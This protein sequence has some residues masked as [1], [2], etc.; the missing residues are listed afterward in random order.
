[1][2][3]FNRKS[4]K[5]ESKKVKKQSEKK[6]DQVVASKKDVEARHGASVKKDVSSEKTA[7]PVKKTKKS[8][9]KNDPDAYKM[10]SYPLVTEKATDLVQFGKY[11]FVVPVSANKQEVTKKIASIYGVTPIKVNI[12]KKRGKKVRH[13]RSFGTTK[14]FKKAIVTVGPEDKIEVYEGV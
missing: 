14:D 9:K 2:G 6:I 7:K 3:L 5:Q 1:M 11:V 10:I 8:E 12:I 13:G 4:K